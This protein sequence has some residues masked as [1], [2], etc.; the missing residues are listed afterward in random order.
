MLN[1][2]LRAAEP[3]IVMVGEVTLGTGAFD[4]QATVQCLEHALQ[5][6][7]RRSR[8]ADVSE[9]RIDTASRV[10]RLFIDESLAV[11][12]RSHSDAD[13]RAVPRFSE[14]DFTSDAFFAFLIEQVNADERDHDLLEFSYV[15]LILGLERGLLP[16]GTDPADIGRLMEGLGQTVE[17]GPTSGDLVLSPRWESP[18]AQGGPWLSKVPAWVSV[19][20]VGLLLLVSI[21]AFQF[22][23]DEES[24]A[25]IVD[26]EFIARPL[27]E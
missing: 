13:D 19:T 27:T 24:Q 20:F 18:V 21:H 10:L 2:L 1:P 14:P 8:D 3:L 15:L 7:E 6:F 5:A 4:P 26:L 22:L 11:A 9:H 23:V 16:S 17:R 25:L 12:V